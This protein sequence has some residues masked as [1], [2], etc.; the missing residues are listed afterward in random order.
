MNLV[1]VTGCQRS[2]SYFYVD[3]LAKIWGYSYV[4]EKE[5]NY[6]DYD[7][8]KKLI[9][10]TNSDLIIHCPSLKGICEL[11]KE[12]YPNSKIIWMYRDKLETEKSMQKI[13]WDLN[14]ALHKLN[15]PLDYSLKQFIDYSLELGIKLFRLGIVSQL[16]NMDSLSHLPNFKKNQGVIGLK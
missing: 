15:L 1:F 16:V 13:N 14:N 10:S 8:L 4:D 11:I 2:G 12:D 6:G 5:F 7:K 3:Y 9:D